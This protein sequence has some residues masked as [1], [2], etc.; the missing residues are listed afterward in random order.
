MPAR[1][2]LFF[3]DHELGTVEPIEADFPNSAGKLT[4][5]REAWEGS[6]GGRLREYFDHCLE[7]DQIFLEEGEEPWQDFIAEREPDLAD[8]I[9]SEDWRLVQEDGASEPITVPL[10]YLDGTLGWR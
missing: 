10:F 3:G 6:T 5:A 9:D 2:V 1:Y 7:A 8:V 4:L